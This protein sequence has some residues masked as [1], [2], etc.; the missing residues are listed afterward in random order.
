MGLERKVA[1]MLAVP[2]ECRNRL[3][4]IAAERN[5]QNQDTVTS[6]STIAADMLCEQLRCQH[7]DEGMEGQSPADER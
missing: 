6:A 1:L 5:L 4:K 2:R 3:R 7:A